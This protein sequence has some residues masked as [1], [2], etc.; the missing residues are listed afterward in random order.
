[1]KRRYVYDETV[2]EVNVWA[3]RYSVFTPRGQEG[4]GYRLQEYITFLKNKGG[5]R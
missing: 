2:D 4:F 3:E 5:T 1:M